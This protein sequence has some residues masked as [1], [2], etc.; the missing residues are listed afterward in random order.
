MLLWPKWLLTVA[1]TFM[2]KCRLTST[3]AGDCCSDAIAA[4]EAEDMVNLVC[5]PASSRW[6]CPLSYWQVPSFARDCSSSL[7]RRF[8]TL[9]ICMKI[10]I[11]AC[12]FFSS[13]SLLVCLFACRCLINNF[14]AI[15]YYN[16]EAMALASYAINKQCLCFLQIVVV[17]QCS[18]FDVYL[19]I[20]MKQIYAF[21]IKLSGV[22]VSHKIVGPSIKF[23]IY[24]KIQQN[25]L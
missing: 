8:T 2:T 17:V 14:W 3:I 15:V 7:W 16:S 13:L 22:M 1:R 6:H 25:N 21:N 11:Y 10:S 23:S 24:H 12:D 18:I 20:T 9:H 4:I 5:H 19:T